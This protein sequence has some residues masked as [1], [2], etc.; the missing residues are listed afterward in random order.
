MTPIVVVAFNRKASLERLLGF[1]NNASYPSTDIPLIISIDKGNNQDVIDVAYAFEWSYGEKQVITHE[2]NLGLRRHIIKCASMSEKYGSVIILEDDLIVSPNFYNYTQ[3]ALKFSKDKDYIGGISLYNH[4]VN[5]HTSDPFWPI[6]D[7]YDNWYFQFASSWGEAWSWEQWRK[8]HVWYEENKNK[9]LRAYN[10]PAYVAA[11]SAKS[12]LKYYIKYLIETNRYFIYP[13]VS[14]SSNCSDKGEHA[15]GED[16]TAFQVPL[17]MSV[18]KTYDFSS[19]DASRAVYDAFYE[20]QLLQ[21]T[22]LDEDVE[23]DLYG[24]KPI[25]EKRY[26]LTSRALDYKVVRSYSC[27]MRPHEANVQYNQPGQDIF[28]YDTSETVKATI[29]S[30]KLKHRQNVYKFKIVKRHQ[31]IEMFMN[32]VHIDVMATLKKIRG[33]SK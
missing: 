16:N 24:Y 7:G 15:C 22:L 5:V 12:W 8:F 17:L 23:V 13:R 3:Q 10:Y 32:Q 4:Q 27:S 9:D 25:G 6:E 18:K 19:L 21:K 14:L 31:A 20:N 30:K 2:E 11:W 28:L 1:I 33:R 29:D 26:I